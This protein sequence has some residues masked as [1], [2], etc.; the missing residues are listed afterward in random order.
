MQRSAPFNTL[1]TVNSV[2]A[3]GERG[4]VDVVMNGRLQLWHKRFLVPMTA[5]ASPTQWRVNR[6]QTVAFKVRDAGDALGGAK[7]A[8]VGKT[9]TTGAT[10]G[11]SITVPARSAPATLSAA[12]TKAGYR[13]TSVTLRV[14]R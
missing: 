6:K 4:P 5:T 7:V 12:V 9:C 8:L 2:A 1:N 14:V 11:C 13:Q 10:G 3:N